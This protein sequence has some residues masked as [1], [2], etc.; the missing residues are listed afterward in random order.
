MGRL[1][2]KKAI[3]T[4]GARGVGREI[5]QAFAAEG[6]DVAVVDVLDESEGG[7]VLGKI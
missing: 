2:G 4:G 3:V 5:A 1:L 6:A 7:E